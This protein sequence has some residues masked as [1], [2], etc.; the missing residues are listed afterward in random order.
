MFYTIFSIGFGCSLTF[1]LQLLSQF[2]QDE[3]S[4]SS[5]KY[6]VPESNG[7]EPVPYS[8]LIHGIGQVSS[9][10]DSQLICGA[11]NSQLMLLLIMI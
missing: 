9:A 6:L 2:L 1:L 3:L 8:A 4:L 5:T 10:Y 7:T 11:Y